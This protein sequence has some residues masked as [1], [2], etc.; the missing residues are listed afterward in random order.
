MLFTW[1]VRLQPF[2]LSAQVVQTSRGSQL[3]SWHVSW[4]STWHFQVDRRRFF[5]FL[6]GG[7]S[8]RAS[9]ATKDC[10]IIGGQSPTVPNSFTQSWN[11]AS[12]RA[13]TKEVGEKAQHSSLPHMKKLWHLPTA[14][15]V[16]LQ[17]W[18]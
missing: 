3:D 11:V 8:L 10:K 9:K 13:S 17:P 15:N 16:C 6:A 14:S 4:R 12:L 5:D 2:I 7:A 1:A 18:H